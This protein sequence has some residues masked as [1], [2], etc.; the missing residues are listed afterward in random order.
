MDSEKR[1]TFLLKLKQNKVAEGLN[2]VAE[3]G[4]PIIHKSIFL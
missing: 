3:G 1:T 4:T 2:K